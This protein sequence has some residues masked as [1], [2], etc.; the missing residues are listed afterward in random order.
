M[1]TVAKPKVFI[2]YTWRLDDP[3]KPKGHSEERGLKLADRLRAAGLDSRIDQYFLRPRHGFVPPQSRPGD[4]VELWVT[5]AREQIQDADFVLL[6]CTAQYAANVCKSPLAGDLTWDQWYAV[7]DDL[8]FKLQECHLTW[9]QWHAMPDDL[10]FK[11]QKY[12]MDERERKKDKVPYTWWDWHFMIQ[13]M[14]SGCAEKQKFIPVGFGPYS[15]VSQ[16][17]PYFIKGEPY[18]NL[19]SNEDFE[20]LLSS[21]RTKFRIRHPREGIFISYSH[22]DKKL[23]NE[24]ISMMDPAIRR[25]VVD[26]WD[27]T[28]I[29]PGAKWREEIQDALSS[30]K[31]AVLL[32]SRNFLASEFIAQHELAP[33]LRAA[34]QEGAT[35]FWIC[36]S[37]CL[38]EQTEIEQYQPAHDVARPLNKMTPPDREAILSEVCAKL[39]R[40]A[41]SR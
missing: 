36:L 1:K 21:I 9:E 11:I 3:S 28:K 32:V 15:S 13:D 25:G 35:V 8:K 5:W 34:E 24:F 33:L 29:K 37:S 38:Y 26:I 18:Y 22:K 4:K 12:Q 14:E 17:V 23:F 30:A 16:H 20:G 31:V 39:I 10:K 19:D 27:D 6:V 2:S 40:L 41:A 7:P